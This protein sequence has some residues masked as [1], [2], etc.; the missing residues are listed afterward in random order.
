M[1]AKG[2]VCCLNR[3]FLSVV[4]ILVFCYFYLF[5]HCNSSHRITR[6]STSATKK[7]LHMAVLLKSFMQLSNARSVCSKV[8]CKLTE[9]GGGRLF[10]RSSP[11]LTR[12]VTDH[13]V[14]MSS[15]KK[16]CILGSGNW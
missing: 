7:G 16:I 9:V 13:L 1:E 8:S 15:Q 4:Y 11:V 10:S 12:V 2:V 6:V 3:R 5:S 14:D